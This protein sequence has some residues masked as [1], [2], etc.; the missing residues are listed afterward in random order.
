MKRD[1]PGS[2]AGKESTYLNLSGGDLGNASN[3]GPAPDSSRQSH[4]K[5]EQ[6]RLGKHTRL[7]GGKPS[8]AESLPA[9]ASDICSQCSSLPTA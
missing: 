9:H 3:P 4:L 5:P 8:A 2:S 7:S 1:F 6:C